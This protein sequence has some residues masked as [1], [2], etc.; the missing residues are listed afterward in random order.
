MR[1]SVEDL[2][3]VIPS[4]YRLVARGELD[5]PVNWKIAVESFLEGYHIRTTHA[6]T[7]CFE[8]IYSSVEHISQNNAIL[9]SR[10]SL[11]YCRSIIP[12]LMVGHIYGE[13][14]CILGIGLVAV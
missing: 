11:T 4:S 3:Q 1:D 6:Q 12:Y 7:F 9:G 13:W 14:Y 8:H 10:I 5:V 2:P